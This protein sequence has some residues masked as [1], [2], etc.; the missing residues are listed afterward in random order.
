VR[1]EVIDQIREGATFLQLLAK[2]FHLNE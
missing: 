1:L 2:K